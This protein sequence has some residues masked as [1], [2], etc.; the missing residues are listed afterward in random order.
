LGDRV[1]DITPPDNRA[2]IELIESRKPAI[3]IFSLIDDKTTL[4]MAKD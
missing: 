1:K 3:S 4:A 2:V